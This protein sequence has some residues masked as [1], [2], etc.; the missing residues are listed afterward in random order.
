[1]ENGFLFSDNHEL[2]KVVPCP[3][4]KLAAL[5]GLERV[6]VFHDKTSGTF[7]ILPRFLNKGGRGEQ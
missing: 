7:P 6:K 5:H 1:M 3:M 2:Y 4:A